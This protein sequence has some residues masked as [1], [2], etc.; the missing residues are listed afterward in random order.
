MNDTTP[1]LD[2]RRLFTELAEQMRTIAV[3]SGVRYRLTI[4]AEDWLLPP[5]MA[6]PVVFFAVEA[7]SF[8]LFGV[9]SEERIRN[10]ELSFS[11]D[12]PQHLMLWV[13]DGV[14]ASAALNAGRPSPVRIFAALAE[15]L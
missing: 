8:E 6:T 3:E 14:F 11:A 15:Q 9:Q 12:G 13:E 10:V 7:L 1:I 5:D 4:H 2:M